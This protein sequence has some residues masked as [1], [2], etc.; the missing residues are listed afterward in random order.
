MGKREKPFTKSLLLSIPG[1]QES[2]SLPFMLLTPKL[3]LW[4]MENK[5]LS[6]KGH[7]SNSSFLI[8][9][10][11]NKAETSYRCAVI[12]SN[13]TCFK[14]LN[15][16]FR[17]DETTSLFQRQ[18]ESAL[19]TTFSSSQVWQSGTTVWLDTRGHSSFTTHKVKQKHTLADRSLFKHYH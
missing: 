17:D 15:C 18:M 9:T 11:I 3:Q 14:R 5:K 19:E 12:Q 10:W 8:L 4:K 16:Y 6:S 2:C 7:S 13:T 1:R